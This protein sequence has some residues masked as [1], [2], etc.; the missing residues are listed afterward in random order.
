MGRQLREDHAARDVM[1]AC[2]GDGFQNC[3]SIW[4]RHFGAARGAQVVRVVTAVGRTGTGVE[5]RKVF[6]QETA[7]RRCLGP[8]LQIADA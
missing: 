1:P 7:N 5:I 6:G 8:T 4:R 2:A 3:V